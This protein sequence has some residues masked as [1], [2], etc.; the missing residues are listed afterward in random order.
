[1]VTDYPFS[2]YHNRSRTVECSAL[3]IGLWSRDNRDRLVV[4]VRLRRTSNAILAMS[5]TW[6]RRRPMNDGDSD[7][8]R[9]YHVVQKI[10]WSCLRRTDRSLFCY[11]CTYT[12]TNGTVTS[13]IKKLTDKFYLSP[14]IVS[15]DTIVTDA[16]PPD[17]Q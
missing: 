14:L 2:R 12:E 11:G 3:D 16:V 15:S 8:A 5:W 9:P 6:W 7:L 13:V 1:M 17:S 10:L 4:T